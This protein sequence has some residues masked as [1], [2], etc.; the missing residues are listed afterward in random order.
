ML[1]PGSL[2]LVKLSGLV[3]IWFSST[4]IHHFLR[5]R[6]WHTILL[7]KTKSKLSYRKNVSTRT[8]QKLSMLPQA[9]RKVLAR[10]KYFYTYTRTEADSRFSLRNVW[11]FG[12]SP[13]S[14]SGQVAYSSHC[15]WLRRYGIDSNT[16]PMAYISVCHFSIVKTDGVSA[17][18]PIRFVLHSR[19]C[20][21]AAKTFSTLLAAAESAI[22]LIII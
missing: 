12:Q 20:C 11:L 18:F 13:P 19:N 6:L 17:T 22:W 2:W 9:V 10:L 8:K 14:I 21:T 15:K 7:W 3:F 5:S 16:G 4:K 1:I